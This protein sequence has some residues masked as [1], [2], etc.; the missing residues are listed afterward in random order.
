VIVSNLALDAIFGINYLEENNVVINLPEKLFET[1][2]YNSDCERKFYVS[3]PKD[4]MAVA[5]I[6]N[7]EFHLKFPESQTIIQP[8]GKDHTVG[9]QTAHTLTF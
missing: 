9:A 2:R 1:R 3:L 6:S 7:P 4:K 8:D 5:I